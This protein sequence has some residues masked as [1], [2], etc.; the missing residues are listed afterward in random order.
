MRTDEIILFLWLRTSLTPLFADNKLNLK[1]VFITI[2]FFDYMFSLTLINLFLNIF[3]S[4]FC[5]FLIGLNQ[6]QVAYAYAAWKFSY[7]FLNRTSVEEFNMLWNQL[8]GEPVSQSRL[9]QLKKRMRNDVATEVID[10]LNIL[11]LSLSLFG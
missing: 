4:F 3:D 5:N 11:V 1:E 8:K 6:F 9:L 7:H 2:F 10:F